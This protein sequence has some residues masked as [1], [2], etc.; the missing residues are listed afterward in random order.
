MD[1][2]LGFLGMRGDLLWQISRR[3]RS[4]CVSWIAQ[5]SGKT[6]TIM[7]SSAGIRESITTLSD[8]QQRLGIAQTQNNAFFAEWADHLPALNLQEQS[9]VDRI[10]HRYDYQR[11]DGLLLESTINLVVTAPLLELLGFIDPPFHLKSPYGIA[12]ALEDPTETIRGFI[13][14]LVLQERLWIL[15]VESKRTGI[16]IPAAFPQLLAYMAA[17]P[18]RQH[19]NYGM[20]TNGDEFVFL[21]LGADGEYDVSRAFSLF[22]RNHELGKVAQILKVLG[23]RVLDLGT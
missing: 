23:Q 8:L 11:I 22:P 9:G 15:T 12:L 19:P 20:A 13:D 6:L 16:S 21:K 1:D 18:D 2:R 14:V 10:K 7:V 17:N 4:N 3:D 5:L